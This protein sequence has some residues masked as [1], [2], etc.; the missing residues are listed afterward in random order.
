MAETLKLDA[1]IFGGGVAGLWLLNRLRNEGY[2]AWLMEKDQL[3]AG[4]SIASQGMIHGGI[5]YSLGGKLTNASTA[6]A[7]M[8]AHWKQCLAGEGDVD[9]RGCNLLSDSYFMWPQHSLRSRLN[10]FLG[11]KA[12]EAKVDKVASEHYPA[13]F[14]NH[15]QGAL[16]Q[17]Q[18]IVLDV[19]SLLHTLAENQSEAIF[20]IDWQ[21][22]TLEKNPDGG[23]NELRFSNGTVIQARHFIFCCGAGTQSL[24]DDNQFD[25]TTMQRRPLRMVMV[26]HTIEEPVYVHC[27]SDK[28][29]MT[30]EVTIT[31]H[32]N[33]AGEPVWYL[34]G[35]LAEQGPRQSEGELIE[36]AR[37]KLTTLF[38]WCDFSKARWSTLAIDRAEQKQSDGT[39]PDGISIAESHNLMLC[40][41]TKLT[42]APNLANT[43][44]NKMQAANTMAGTSAEP[45]PPD[46]LQRPELASTPWEQF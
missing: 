19:P 1:L 43:V 36:T 12:L 18:D 34:G 22:A 40:W 5:K 37:N 39:R 45:S 28:L 3:G 26:K 35:E 32:R 46:F 15:I 31:S 13:F 9:L 10:A 23:I 17:L 33:A 38:P 6:I 30:P 44:L 27:V 42:L 2:S 25:F 7:D 14:K 8:P 16:Y 4:Q 29:S 24:M 21:Q 20:K 41:P 11:S